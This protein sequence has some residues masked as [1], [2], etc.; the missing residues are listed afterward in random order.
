MREFAERL[1]ILAALKTA[2]ENKLL[3][4]A[5]VDG[6]RVSRFG[7]HDRVLVPLFE[8]VGTG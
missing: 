4:D 8:S 1:I 2:L 3:V 6:P 5:E 7:I